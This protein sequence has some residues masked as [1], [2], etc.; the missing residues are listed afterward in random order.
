MS[1]ATGVYMFS[2][3]VCT[4]NVNYVFT[5]LVVEDSIISVA[6]EYES[7]GYRDCGS[8][9]ALCKVKKNDH[10]WI[11]TTDFADSS[12]LHFLYQAGSTGTN[13]F[14]GLLLYKE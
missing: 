11:R 2:W 13:S 9:T 12:K 10:V 7:N 4:V 3:T 1:P 14:M 6:G 8:M 5:E